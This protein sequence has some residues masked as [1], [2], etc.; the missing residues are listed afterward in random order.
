MQKEVET[1]ISNI[2][3]LDKKLIIKYTWINRKKLKQLHYEKNK[4]NL[5]YKKI[6]FMNYCNI[7]RISI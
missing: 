7:I 6:T 3:K 2:N 5:I 4:N 1:D